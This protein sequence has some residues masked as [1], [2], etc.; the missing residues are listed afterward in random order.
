M[1]V[2]FG[3]CMLIN[4]S[5][6][7]IFLYV[8]SLTYLLLF[9][10][11][12]FILGL[13]FFSEFSFVL[14]ILSSML[15]VFCMLFFFSSNFLMLYVFFELS[16]FP[17]LLMIMGFGYQIE[18]I[19]SLYYLL[20]YSII[21]SL[22]FFYVYYN[23]YFF[24]G[25][26]ILYF[27]VSWEFFFMLSLMF[28][29]KFPVFFFHL[30]LPK[31]HVEAPTTASML[32]AGLLLKLG[33][34][35]FLRIMKSMNFIYSNWW[36]YISFL[37]MLI[38]IF[39]CFFQSDVKSLAAYS[40]ITH[41]SFLLM[42]IVFI[43]LPSKLSSLLLMMGHG[44][45]SSLLFFFIG[46]FYYYNSTRMIYY[47]NGFFS[48]NVFYSMCLSL[49]FMF[50]VGLPLSLNFFSEFF[51]I[52]SGMFFSKLVIF[53]LFF[54]FFCGFYYSCYLLVLSFMGS[55]NVCLGLWKSYQS[56]FLLVMCTNV[57]WFSLMN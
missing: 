26:V 7:G 3:V 20:F 2:I 32:L 14:N 42:C 39:I 1:M 12:M 35:G 10:M 57:F 21:C 23:V 56:M 54:Y 8:D 40:S 51:S 34:T 9:F 4:Y 43:Y 49:V 52:V 5:W 18:K 13:V 22:P 47:F 36:V 41:M 25:F 31:A 29:M 50:N 17:I 24:L 16:V 38:S 37:G 11:M 6:W 53:V 19:N 27:F 44:Y 55:Y 33:T 45:V 30:W 48:F 15:I 28:M 46:E